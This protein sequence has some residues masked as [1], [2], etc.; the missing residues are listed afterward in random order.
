MNDVVTEAQ[1][2]VITLVICQINLLLCLVNDILDLK[3]IEQNRF[4]ERIE[5]FRT[6]QT[7]KFII[8]IFAQQAQMQRSEISFDVVPL[9][10]D[11]ESVKRLL[12][13]PLASE[14]LPSYLKGD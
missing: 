8:D 6:L 10:L 7:F 4:V 13:N 12:H 3:M 9:P 5:T 2:K 14:E 11:E 1:S